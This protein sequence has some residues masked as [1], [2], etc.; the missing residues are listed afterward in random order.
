[1]SELSIFRLW[2]QFSPFFYYVLL[3]IPQARVNTFQ[4]AFGI[5]VDD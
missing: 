4:L 5:N 1:M 3:T 2:N